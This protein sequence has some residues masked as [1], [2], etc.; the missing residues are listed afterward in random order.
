M[1]ETLRRQ[2]SAETSF[3]VSP[4]S[5]RDVSAGHFQ[6]AQVD[7]SGKIRTHMGGAQ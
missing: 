4:T 6:R 2:N 5:I 3:Q 1:K 7:K